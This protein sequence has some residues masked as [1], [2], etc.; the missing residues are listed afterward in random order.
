MLNKEQLTTLNKIMKI[1]F[2]NYQ[3]NNIICISSIIEV[4]NF[5]NCICSVEMTTNIDD[6]E[7]IKFY[8][9]VCECYNSDGKFPCIFTMHNK[10]AITAELKITSYDSNMEY[11]YIYSLSMKEKEAS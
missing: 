5:S 8:N 11:M 7:I 4:V 9:L 10:Y 3:I 2:N 6:N 1:D